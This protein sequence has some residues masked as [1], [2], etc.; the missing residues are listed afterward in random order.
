[1]KDLNDFLFFRANPLTGTI[2]LRNPS[3]SIFLEGMHQRFDFL[4][5]D[6]HQGK[7]VY[8]TILFD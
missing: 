5:G 4:R 3:S 8:E 6:I 7:V 2:L 1:M